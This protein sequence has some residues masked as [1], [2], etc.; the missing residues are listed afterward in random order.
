MKVQL[1]LLHFAGGNRYSYQFLLPFLEQFD[2]TPVELPGR[3]KRSREPLIKDFDEAVSDLY[4]Q[5]IASRTSGPFALFGH[6]MGALLAFQIC[7]MLEQK[8]RGP[9]YLF[10]S[11]NSGPASSHKV[12]RHLL[13]RNAL[14]DELKT[15]GGVPDG[16]FN[17]DGLFDFFEPMIR[18]D[19]E[20]I[21]KKTIQFTARVKA[22]IHAFMGTEEDDVDGIGNWRSLTQSQ[23]KYQLFKGGHFFIHHHACD[24]ARLISMELDKAHF[25]IS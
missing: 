13:E 12:S 21:E 14:V 7:V 15:I 4:Q 18:A 2:C 1:Y 3:G 19:F 23:F 17:D 10:V 5:I 20:I 25:Q 8:G 6:S 11:G 24:L 22:P 16:F 9:N